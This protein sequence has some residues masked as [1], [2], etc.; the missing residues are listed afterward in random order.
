MEE[1]ALAAV[2]LDAILPERP[3]GLHAALRLAASKETFLG[4]FRS[5]EE[6]LA[7]RELG[8]TG[9]VGEF[10]TRFAARS[11]LSRASTFHRASTTCSVSRPCCCPPLRTG[12]RPRCRLSDPTL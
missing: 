11:T 12:F 3:R 8:V 4:W 9:F 5:Y 6:R 2:L 7:R 1:R 10:A